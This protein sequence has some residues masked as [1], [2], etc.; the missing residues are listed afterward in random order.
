MYHEEDI[1]LRKSVKRKMIRS[2]LLVVQSEK[3]DI[4]HTRKPKLLPKYLEKTKID[5]ILKRARNDNKR[6]NLILLTL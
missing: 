6:N 5:E 2:C 3:S 1:D 4:K